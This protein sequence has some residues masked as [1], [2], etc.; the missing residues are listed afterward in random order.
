VLLPFSDLLYH[1]LQ[2]K[3]EYSAEPSEEAGRVLRFGIYHICTSH[4][5]NASLQKSI[6]YILK[7]QYRVIK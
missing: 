7:I 4:Q 1:V 3:E 2:E 6:Y 5:I